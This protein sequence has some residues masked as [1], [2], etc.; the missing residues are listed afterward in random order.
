MS[1]KAAMFAAAFAVSLFFGL[2]SGLR[3]FFII[4]AALFAVIAVS[5]LSAL[6]CAALVRPSFHLEES[7]AERLKFGKLK[8]SLKGAVL[9]PAVVRIAVADAGKT[10]K[11]EKMNDNSVFLNIGKINKSYDFKIKCPHCGKLVCGAEK[12]YAE[13]IFGLFSIPFFFKGKEPERKKN[14]RVLPVSYFSDFSGG[15]IDFVKGNLNSSAKSDLSGEIPDDLRDYHPGDPIKMINWKLSAKLNRLLVRIYERL[16][17]PK[18][19]VLLDGALLNKDPKI[20]DIALE[21]SLAL[22]CA[23]GGKKE[24]FAFFAER[25]KSGNFSHSIET[26]GDLLNFP[27]LLTELEGG[28]EDCEYNISPASA[29]EII[30]MGA[31]LFI[32]SDNVSKNSL[33][34]IS[35]MINGG[36]RVK[37][38]IPFKKE[39]P[40]FLTAEAGMGFDAVYISDCCQ[41]T[42]KVG[43]LIC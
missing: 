24:S 1:F 33:K 11:S 34:K 39:I 22:A 14:I 32:I 29:E 36:I 20:C 7:V 28:E 15:G 5:L 42:E 19:F 25:L 18:A 31:D 9:L 37:F 27:Y 16:D 30:S 13:D 8:I 43:A 10:L 2:G 6:L 21:T 41:I 17:D 38:I 3:E 4:S 40:D 12:I 23:F 35:N 26:G